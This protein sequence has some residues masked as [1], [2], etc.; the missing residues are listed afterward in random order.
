MES[1]VM[2]NN[3]EGNLRKTQN[4]GLRLRQKRSLHKVNE[5]FAEGAQRRVWGFR[6]LPEKSAGAEDGFTLVEVLIAMIILAI[7]LLSIA[8]A[9]A[10][11]MVLLVNTPV[12][13]AAKELAFEIIDDYVVRKDTGITAGSGDLDGEITTRD[14]RVFYVKTDSSVAAA[15]DPDRCN[16]G[17]L[18]VNITVTYCTSAGL[19]CLGTSGERRYNVMACIS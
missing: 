8:T 17:D 12:Q 16:N 10:Q 6:R 19:S 15:S 3:N 5:H 1:A 14:N 11:G 4:Q 18:E 2:K 13:L 9:F 7:G